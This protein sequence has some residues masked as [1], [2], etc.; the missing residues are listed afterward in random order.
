M[1]ML[2]RTTRN[3]IV[4]WSSPSRIFARKNISSL[5]TDNH[6][7]NFRIKSMHLFASSLGPPP[8]NGGV[9]QSR[10]V[11]EFLASSLG[12]MDTPIYATITGKK[13]LSTDESS[14]NSKKRKCNESLYSDII[15]PQIN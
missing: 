1:S 12:P 13:M 5:H 7:C 3:K 10:Q 4:F 15:K 2:G 8:L 6:T 9:G 14:T 11:H